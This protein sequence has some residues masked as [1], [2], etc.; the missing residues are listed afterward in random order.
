MTDIP[1]SPDVAVI[2]AG[3]AGLRCARVLQDAGLDVVVLEAGDDIGGRVRTDLIDGYRVDRGFQV[4]NPAYPQVRRHVD[5]R[6]LRLARFPAGA[7]VRRDDG[8]A[9]AA[10]PRRSPRLLGATLRSPYTD[11]A[12]LV[13]LGR[14]AAPALGPVD[15]LLARPDESRA[16]SMEQAGLDGVLREELLEPFLAGV[17]LERDG[18]S[19]ATY[20]RLLVRSFVLASPGLPAAGMSALPHQLAAGLTR[21]PVLGVRAE[22]VRLDGSRWHVEGSDVRAR[23]VVIATDPTTA[24][25]LT[26]LATPAGKG[27][28]TWWFASDEP[29]SDDATLRVEGRR[30]A[31]PLVNTAVVTNTAPSYAP[32]GRH[33]VQGTALHADGPASD[34]DARLHLADLW[35]Q[36]TSRWELVAR[37]DVGYSLPAQPAP[38]DARRPVDLGEGLFV[39]GDHRDTGSIQGALAS[40]A[41]TGRAVIAHLGL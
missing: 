38:L 2:G 4:L 30:G 12:D 11:P 18:S 24:H 16:E 31:G 3:L 36:D 15:R 22:G 40:G 41:R 23:S 9:T 27:L 10:D 37:H 14:W 34:D 5:V 28:T 1:T 25:E 8:T 32:A 35:Q 39:C 29:V 21:R 17:V 33:L 19:S 20:T 7:T 26:D 13:A 6:A